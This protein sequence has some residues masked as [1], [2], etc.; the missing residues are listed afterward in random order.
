MKRSIHT[1]ADEGKKKNRCSSL[2]PCAL[3]REQR[4][5]ELSTASTSP[6]LL[7]LPFLMSPNPPP[8]PSFNPRGPS[9]LRQPA[10][11]S[12]GFGE[13]RRGGGLGSVTRGV[14]GSLKD[15]GVWLSIPPQPEPKRPPRPNTARPTRSPWHYSLPHENNDTSTES[16]GRIKPVSKW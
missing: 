13:R 4:R 3:V 12:T 11:G 7:L 10:L 5:Q 8:P 9:R 16:H 6:L 2:F 1:W 14:S 15:L